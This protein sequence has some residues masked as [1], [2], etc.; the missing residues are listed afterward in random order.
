MLP[1]TQI[2]RL[3]VA[4]GVVTALSSCAADAQDRPS[5]LA[6]GQTAGTAA[7]ASKINADVPYWQTRGVG[8]LMVESRAGRTVV[9]VS[10]TDAARAEEL[11]PAYY[12]SADLVI[13]TPTASDM[14]Y[15][16][17]VPPGPAPSDPTVPK[18]VLP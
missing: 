10:A 15:R 12:G 1:G 7:L 13:E 8:I 6:G 5:A 9:T 2:A 11:L 14:V 4:A 17:G 3:L 16:G 18:S